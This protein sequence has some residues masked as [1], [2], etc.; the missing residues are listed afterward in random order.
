MGGGVSVSQSMVPLKVKKKKK[1]VEEWCPDR[2]KISPWFSR[3]P[4]CYE[5]ETGDGE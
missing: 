4:K 1:K 5:C 3:S 2:L